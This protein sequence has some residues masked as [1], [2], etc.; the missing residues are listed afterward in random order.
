M[1]VYKP[2]NSQGFLTDFLL[3]DQSR[4]IFHGLQKLTLIY[5]CNELGDFL[6]YYQDD[7]LNLRSLT[8]EGYGIQ[9]SWLDLIPS[10]LNHIRELYLIDVNIIGREDDFSYFLEQLTNLET[11]VQIGGK[12]KISF[13][14]NELSKYFPNLRKF[15]YDIGKPNET[16]PLIFI[17]KYTFLKKF[18]NLQALEVGESSHANN[19]CRNVFSVLEFVPNIK[20]LSIYKIKNIFYQE[21]E[22]QQMVEAIKR[23][24]N[25]RKHSKFYDDYVTVEVNLKQYR[26]F[27]AICGMKNFIKLSINKVNHT[28]QL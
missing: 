21:R 4:L 12:F 6:S 3:V 9:K 27:Q 25:N 22:I 14:V 23:I 10:S 1:V 28:K 15:G 20:Q 24:I 7:L 19:F 13:V 5:K 8:L 26:D 18:Y 2:K 16:S 11:F 17:E